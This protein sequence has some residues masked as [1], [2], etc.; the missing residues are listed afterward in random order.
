MCKVVLNCRLVVLSGLSSFVNSYKKKEK[1]KKKPKKKN[2]LVGTNKWT[3]DIPNAFHA[4][5]CN[6]HLLLVEASTVELQWLKL[7]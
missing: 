2:W 5:T 4:G 3:A 7:L 6:M 1:D